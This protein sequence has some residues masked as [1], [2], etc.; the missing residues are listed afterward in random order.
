MAYKLELPVDTH[1]HNVVHV[2]QFKPS[3]GYTGQLVPLP[4]GVNQDL[5]YEPLAILDRKMV[6]RENQADVQLLIDWNNL[7]PAE[8]TWEFASEIRRRF[9]MFSLEDKGSVG[10]VL[11]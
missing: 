5:Q 11:L 3:F 10:G 1:I 6:K 9:P 2:S 7:S 4:K 8:A